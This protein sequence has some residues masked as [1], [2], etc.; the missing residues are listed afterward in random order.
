MKKQNNILRWEA[1]LFLFFL[2]SLLSTSV[3]AQIDVRWVLQSEGKSHEFINSMAVDPYNN[4]YITGRYYDYDLILGDSTLS[5]HGQNN[6][7]AYVAKISPE[8]QVLYAKSIYSRNAL[9]DYTYVDTDN[10][11]NLY[12]ANSTGGRYMLY[13]RDTVRGEDTSEYKERVEFVKFDPTGRLLYSR[14][15]EVDTG[16]TVN[17]MGAIKV[18]TFHHC[19]YTV[20]RSFSKQIRF[21]DYIIRRPRDTTFLYGVYLVKWTLDGTPLWS[22]ALYGRAYKGQ[23]FRGPFSIGTNRKGDVWITGTVLNDGP[24]KRIYLQDTVLEYDFVPPEKNES[25]F[26]IYLNADGQYQWSKFLIV[27]EKIISSQ[28][29]YLTGVDSENNVYLNGNFRGHYMILDGDTI[30]NK[31][32]EYWRSS[33]YLIKYSPEGERLWIK[34]R[35]LNSSSLG[36]TMAIDSED[37]IYLQ[38]SFSSDTIVIQGD[39]LYRSFPN[40]NSSNYDI[41]LTRYNRK[42]ELDWSYSFGGPDYDQRGYIGIIG[43]NEVY[44]TGA[45]S[46]T[47]LDLAGHTLTN[48]YGDKEEYGKPFN[49]FVA[50][51]KI[52]PKTGVSEVPEGYKGMRASY[53]PGLLKAWVSGPE[54][55]QEVR[56]YDLSGKVV[57]RAEPGEKPGEYRFRLSGVPAG[58]YVVA[59]HYETGIRS[60]K[61]MVGE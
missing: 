5:T 33:Y 31:N 61:V 20:F 51:V 60:L 3:P 11:G 48:P 18:D 34:S 50:R 53:T 7:P 57:R 59:A 13:G 54:S 14:V 26:V 38:T 45:Y 29:S 35:N 27:G 24:D 25:G 37:Y 30:Y 16:F 56:L 43:K 8:G 49:I 58:V 12:L 1:A 46:S 21:G 32:K 19:L 6:S 17:Y 55:P 47:E 39:T 10:E 41:V 23:N 28:S 2:L 40:G 36:E 4:T 44:F 52:D 9:P 42:G 15:S 22:Y